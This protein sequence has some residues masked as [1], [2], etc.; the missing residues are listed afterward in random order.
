MGRL[1]QYWCRRKG[2]L[3]TLLT[4]GVPRGDGQRLRRLVVVPLF[5]GVIAALGS[6][7]LF[8]LLGLVTN[9][10]LGE[11]AGH[12][13][14]RTALEGGG[15]AV[16]ALGFGLWP[17]L[18]IAGAGAAVAATLCRA[19]A[20]EARGHGT[21]AAIETAHERPLGIRPRVPVVKLLASALTIGSGGSAGTEGPAAQI[22]AAAGSVFARRA[23]LSPEE[24]RTAVVIGLAAGVG[25]I[26]TAPFGAALM[27]CEVLY[28]RGMDAGLLPRA[29]IASVTA[30]L[31][32][33]LF[34]GFGPLFGRN[35]SAGA[36]FG[37]VD[38]GLYLILGLLCGLHGR[39]YVWAFY[40]VHDFAEKR[41]RRWIWQIGLPVA[42]AVAAAGIGMAVPGVLGTGYGMLQSFADGTPLAATSLTLLLLL[43]W[44]KTLATVLTV[45]TGGSGGLFGP[46]LVVGGA[47]GASV[48]AV[49]ERAGLPV[50]GPLSYTVVGMAALLGPVARAPIGVLIMAVETVGAAALL[51]PALLG[52]GVSIL[53]VQGTTLYRSQRDSPPGSATLPSA[54][55]IAPRSHDRSQPVPESEVSGSGPGPSPCRD[56]AVS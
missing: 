45:G 55:S 11:L 1:S 30:W 41:P 29:L 49:A 50:A 32:F 25:A 31:V 35:A 8:A 39:L 51:P 21:D 47:L 14:A 19:L 53:V 5:V 16:G 22:S 43:P 26:F 20:P 48:W 37:W 2:Q 12:H 33:G 56:S 52:T 6:A 9:L 7:G 4:G 40:R 18:L 15:G 34:F 46:A 23:R 17:V 27:A 38:L 44:A 3:A 24:A 42:G 54:R 13:P 10:L 28:R 36:A